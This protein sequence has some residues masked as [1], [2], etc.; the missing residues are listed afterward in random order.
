[1]VQILRLN[2][3]G[4]ELLIVLVFF[5]L[6]YYVSLRSEFHY[7]YCIKRCSVRLH[8]QLFVGGLICYLHYLC[9]FA[10]SGVQHILW[11]FFFVLS[12]LCCQVSL[13]YPF[14]IA[15]S[16]FSNVYLHL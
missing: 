2:L 5:V 6:F 9:L 16:V 8:L 13:D 11:F 4:S 15:P 3:V 1:M 10:Y 12:T 14:L 7:D